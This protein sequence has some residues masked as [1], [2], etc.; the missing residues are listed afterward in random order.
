MEITVENFQEKFDTIAKSIRTAEFIAF[1]TEFTGCK[2]GLADKCHEYD[3]LEDKYRKNSS[4]VK[5]FL[6][7]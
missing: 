1:D 5:K 7:F 3:S 4:A 2:T 6:A